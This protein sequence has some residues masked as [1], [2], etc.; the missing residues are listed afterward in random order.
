MSCHVSQGCWRWSLVRAALLVV[1]SL[2]LAGCGGGGSEGAA[3]EDTT[4]YSVPGHDVS[5]RVPASWAA[6]DSSS[7]D[8]E[9]ER[10]QKEHPSF[11]DVKEELSTRLWMTGPGEA[12]L[13]AEAGGETRLVVTVRPGSAKA[14]LEE[15]MR[16]NLKGLESDP[17]DMGITIEGPKDE[18]VE[19][20]EAGTSWRL[21]WSYRG[22]LGRVQLLQH[23]LVQHG[24]TYMFSYSTLR[25]YEQAAGVFD[26][27][28]ESIRI[29]PPKSTP[30]TSTRDYEATELVGLGGESSA[31]AINDQGQ[32]VGFSETASGEWHAVLW[33]DGKVTDLGTLGGES[34]SAT[35]I[36]DEGQVVG[37]SETAS[38]EEHAFLWEDGKM[39][40]LGTLG[41]NWSTAFAI[42]DQG[43]VVGISDA[44]EDS[45]DVRTF[46]WEDGKMTDFEIPAGERGGATDINNRGQVVGASTPSEG[47]LEVR[48]FLWED[49]KMTDLGTL[50]G[51]PT[52]ALA[53]NDGG[54]V[55]GFGGLF[56][57]HR[58]FLWEDGEM[59]DLGALEDDS[60]SSANGI[61]DR[62]Q[63]VG[64]SGPETEERAVIWEVGN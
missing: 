64:V 21:R 24:N 26:R 29:V 61:N 43:Q 60:S 57:P 5:V 56:P 13:A 49:G 18:V 34:S 16:D 10:F 30:S 9:L 40:D 36:N 39:T 7:S 42:N 37:S 14:T 63:I 38:G 35:A 22:D 33:H 46:L 4:E 8:E 11:L 45:L 28:S 53:I 23:T 19:L 50:A 51:Q 31:D 27:S 6:V 12:L 41:G 47:S 17:L 2:V 15:H 58:A 44:S 48:A 59:T 62:G 32:V 3:G 25:P 54:Q 20:L 1:V 52:M 55:V